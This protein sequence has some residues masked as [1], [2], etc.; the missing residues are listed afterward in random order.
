MKDL[1]IPRGPRH[2][3]ERAF[4]DSVAAC[5]LIDA[6]ALISLAPQ[7]ELIPVLQAH[8]EDPAGLSQVLLSVCGIAACE[9][10]YDGQALAECREWVSAPLDPR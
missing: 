3:G 5:T 2:A 9:E 8:M 7:Y 10:V 6:A 1:K 4:R